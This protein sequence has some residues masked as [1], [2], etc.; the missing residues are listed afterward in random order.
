MSEIEDP[1]ADVERL[2]RQLGRERSRRQAAEQIGDRLTSELYATV[3]EL[4]RAQAEILDRSELA[5]LIEQVARR[6]RQA[7]DTDTLVDLCLAEIADLSVADRCQVHIS[8]SGVGMGLGKWSDD[9]EMLHPA[10][11]SQLPAP[12]AALLADHTGPLPLVVERQSID[13]VLGCR[14]VA[15]IPVRA[16]SRHLGWLL[17]LSVEP[18]RWSDRELAISD[19]VGWP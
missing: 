5:R 16:A 1:G 17:L 11:L 19:G 10:R 9:R 7:Q 12:L 3:E 18:R 13:S 2:R 8:E 6:L 15:A 14:S 4:R